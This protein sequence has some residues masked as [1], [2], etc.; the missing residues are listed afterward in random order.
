MLCIKAIS[1]YNK[2]VEKQ[3]IISLHQILRKVESCST[4]DHRSGKVD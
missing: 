2:I 4:S 3:E 1:K